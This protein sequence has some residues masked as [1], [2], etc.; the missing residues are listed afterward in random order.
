MQLGA[1]AEAGIHKPQIAQVFI[2]SLIEIETIVLV[3]NVA[4]PIEPQPTQVIQKKI[5]PRTGLG[6]GVQVLHPHQHA[7]T[8]APS[9]KPGKKHGVHVTQMHTARR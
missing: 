5:G 6:A 3:D 4:I 2:S 9:R 7:P 1:R 8:A